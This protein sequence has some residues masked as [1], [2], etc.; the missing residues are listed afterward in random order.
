MSDYDARAREYGFAS[1]EEIVEIMNRNP[2]TVLLDVRTLEEISET[3]ALKIG[4][5]PWVTSSCTP[6]ACPELE[7][8]AHKLLPDKNGE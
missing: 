5:H 2:S 8:E 6:N 3:G 1:V 7:T 4:N